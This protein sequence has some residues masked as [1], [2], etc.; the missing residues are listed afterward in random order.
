MRFSG[1]GLK[2]PVVAFLGIVLLVVVTVGTS[3]ASSGESGGGGITVI[4]DASAIIQIINFIVL[5]L[6]LNFLLYRPIRKVIQQ[7]KEKIQGLELSIETSGE[8]AEEKERAFVQ[9]IKDA[10]VKGMREKDA[11]LQE[12]G[13][14]EK[15]ILEQINAK[16]QAELAEVRSRIAVD[17]D[18]TR[19]ALSK[20]VDTFANA[21]SKKILGRSI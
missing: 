19:E 11:L 12:A 8:S 6:I 1:S 21:I 9:G 13:E 14:E 18:S 5:I 17:V 2:G 20:Q 7:R 4:P 15:R 3:V 16:A 10:R